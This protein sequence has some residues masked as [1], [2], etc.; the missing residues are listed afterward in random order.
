MGI[1]SWIVIGGVAGLAARFVTKRHLGSRGSLSGAS[2][3][4]SLEPSCCSSSTVSSRT[5]AGA[6]ARRAQRRQVAT[7]A[8]KW[9]ARWIPL[10]DRPARRSRQ[11]RPIVERAPPPGQ[12]PQ[13]RHVA[14]VSPAR[15]IGRACTSTL[16]P[17]SFC[18]S[19]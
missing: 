1:L 16:A 5:E 6:E 3:P 18:S 19:S 10:N 9:R 7:S 17:R 2:W 11:S 13:A 12:R 4:R 8:D 15:P 14:R